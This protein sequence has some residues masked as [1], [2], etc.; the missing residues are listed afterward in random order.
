MNAKINKLLYEWGVQ[1]HL[2]GF[3]YLKNAVK[4]VSKDPKN[5]HQ[6]TKVLYPAIAKANDTTAS[7]VE[8]DIRHA[9]EIA[10]Y[11]M[12]DD[13]VYKHFGRTIGPYGSVTNSMFIAALAH[14]YELMEDNND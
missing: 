7:R 11:N 9:I 12:G 3:I 1:P 10:L 4:L 5:L 13:E 8:R 14:S 2:L 6:I